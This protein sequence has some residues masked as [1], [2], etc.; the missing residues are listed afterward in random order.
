M[1]ALAHC[2]CRREVEVEE[3]EQGHQHQRVGPPPSKRSKVEE[4][5]EG[6]VGGPHRGGSRQRQGSSV[7]G[8]ASLAESLMDAVCDVEQISHFEGLNCL[9]AQHMDGGLMA[10]AHGDRSHSC[11]LRNMAFQLST[12]DFVRLTLCVSER[13]LA[14][15]LKVR[16]CYGNTDLTWCV[17]MR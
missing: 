11:L 1:N 5:K 6:R 12:H 7:A 4:E 13:E 14:S 17:Q 3:E 10:I 15:E 16:A 2:W 8:A 9:H